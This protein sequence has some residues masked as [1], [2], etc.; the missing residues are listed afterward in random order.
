MPKV[1][2]CYNVQG[3]Y[4]TEDNSKG[5]VYRQI[6][7]K[8]ST[9]ELGV[10]FNDVAPGGNTKDHSHAGLH[11]TLVAKGCGQLKSG[12]TIVEI[13]EG[14]VIYLLPYEPHCFF[15]TGDTVLRL[16]GIQG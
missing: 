13:S 10:V 15:N 9:Y 4:T 1:I 5:L 7:K 6:Y 14:D 2:N 3:D 16:F 12:N 11:I 8:D